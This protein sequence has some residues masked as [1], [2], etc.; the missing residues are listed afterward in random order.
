MESR[1]HQAVRIP[2][3][4]GAHC[5]GS[6][7]QGFRRA[8]PRGPSPDVVANIGKVHFIRIA[9]DFRSL[10]VK[11]LIGIRIFVVVGELT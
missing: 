8:R 2:A 4:D 7:G 6:C 10:G 11:R 5:A 1:N 9:H 3:I